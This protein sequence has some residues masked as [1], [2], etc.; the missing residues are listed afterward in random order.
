MCNV[1]VNKAHRLPFNGVC[2]G[3]YQSSVTHQNFVMMS[4]S[5]DDEPAKKS[6]GRPPAS[7]HRSFGHPN[8]R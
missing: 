2:L 7:G 8:N 5:G 6:L 1:G 3:A 4:L